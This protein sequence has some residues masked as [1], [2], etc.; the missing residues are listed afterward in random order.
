MMK[1]KWVKFEQKKKIN[2]W[3]YFFVHHQ[4]HHRA[5]HTFIILHSSAMMLKR[6]RILKQKKIV[7]MSC[8]Q[9][10]KKLKRIYSFLVTKW[11]YH[12]CW[13]I[14]ENSKKKSNESLKNSENCISSSTSEAFNSVELTSKA[15]LKRLY[16]L[17]SSSSKSDKQTKSIKESENQFNYKDFHREHLTKFKKEAHMYNVFKALFMSDHMSLLNIKA[18]S[19]STST[20]SQ[21]YREIR[22][23]AEWSH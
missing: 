11:Q 14:L 10:K 18:L 21:T 20:K 6:R 2:K 5:R 19:L 15:T 22:R 23:S 8:H 9:L 17:K 13:V 1:S 16:N 12:Q 3:T 4:A 7:S